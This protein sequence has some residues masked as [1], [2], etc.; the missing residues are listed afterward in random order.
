MIN[1]IENDAN[2]NPQKI[3]DVKRNNALTLFPRFKDSFS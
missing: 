3:E 1:T 2:F